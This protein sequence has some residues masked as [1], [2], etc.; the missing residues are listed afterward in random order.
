[1]QDHYETL[2]VARDASPDEIRAAYRRAAKDAHPD[3]EGGSTERMQAVN[4]AYDVLADAERRQAY[5]A[6]DFEGSP[7]AVAKA[8]LRSIFVEAIQENAPDPIKFAETKLDASERGAREKALVMSAAIRRME[9]QRKRITAKGA[10]DL[11]H[12]ILEG[13][14]RSAEDDIRTMEQNIE[15]VALVRTLL[16][17]EYERGPNACDTDLVRKDLDMAMA[18]AMST[19]M[20]S[21][22]SCNF[23]W[24]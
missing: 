14:I 23:D 16:R 5:D 22:G 18:M 4:A 1:M 11:Y 9:K 17:A 13:A 3:R 10:R 8:I 21:D 24:R 7:Q 19:S 12:E 6:G 2:G 20:R 15:N